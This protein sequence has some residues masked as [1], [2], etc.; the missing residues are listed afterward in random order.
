VIKKGDKNEK[1]IIRVDNHYRDC[2]KAILKTS[3][4]LIRDLD[5]HNIHKEH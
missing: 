5:E 4:I 3:G 2:C 1:E